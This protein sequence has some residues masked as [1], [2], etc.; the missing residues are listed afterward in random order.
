MVMAT[1]G[2]AERMNY[3]IQ[4]ANALLAAGWVVVDS[5]V[6]QYM[7]TATGIHIAV[8]DATQP[9]PSAKILYE[10]LS[11][12]GISAQFDSIGPKADPQAIQLIVG[13]K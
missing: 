8:R 2:D 1:V 10:A 12:V 4:L 7:V 13:G 5:A 3:A 6:E 9:P 11:G